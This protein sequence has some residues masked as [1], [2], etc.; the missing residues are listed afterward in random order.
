MRLLTFHRMVQ[1]ATDRRLHKLLNRIAVRRRPNDSPRKYMRYNLC[2]IIL[3]ELLE[4]D[5]RR[6]DSNGRINGR[7]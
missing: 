7:G 3:S 6:L 5:M 2:R 1:R 4:R